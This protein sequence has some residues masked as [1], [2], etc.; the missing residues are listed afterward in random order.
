ML[1]KYRAKRVGNFSSKLEAS[2]YAYLEAQEDVS[3]I[4]CQQKVYLTEAR[5]LYIADFSYLRCGKLTYGEAKGV[6]TATWRLKKKLWKFYGPAP[7]EIYMGSYAR[8]YLA[9]EIKV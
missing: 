8:P 4:K 1:N 7:L 3:E 9:E 2:V 5:I 6:E